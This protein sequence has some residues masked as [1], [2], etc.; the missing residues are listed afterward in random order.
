[1]TLTIKTFDNIYPS[2]YDFENLECAYIKARRSK[3]S[4]D[5]VLRFSFNLESNLIQVQNELIYKTFETGRYRFFYVYDPKTRL[6][7]SLP[8]KDRVVQHALCNIVEPLFEPRFI[9]DSYACRKGKGMHAGA[10]RVT[11]FLRETKRKWG[12]V[13]CLK[14]DIEKYFPSINHSILKR[15]IRRR[16][17]CPDTLWLIDEIID[18]SGGGDWER[19]GLPIGNLTSQL[20]ANVYLDV[21]DHFV[22]EEL[23]ERYY[24]R[25]MD[26]FIILGPDKSH[27]WGVKHEIEHFLDEK[28]SLRLNGKTGIAPIEQSIDFLGYRIWS[29]HRRLRKSSKKRMKRKLKAFQRKYKNN[30]MEFEKINAC[31]QSWL[32]HARH[33]DSYNLC[34][35]LLNGTIFTKN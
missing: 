12:N 32:G 21:L 28:L 33:C 35:K 5:E 10:N 34:K 15:V 18:S 14:C 9:F 25:Y 30:E 20:W 16:I 19:R 7:A 22:K 23:R 26:D 27:L 1:V 4:Q 17:S 31:I 6:V 29:T 24:V 3:R 2:I 11:S 8:F 13:Y